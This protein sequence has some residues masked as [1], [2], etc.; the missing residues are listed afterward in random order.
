MNKLGQKLPPLK[1]RR[2][3]KKYQKEEDEIKR[4]LHKANQYWNDWKLQI[5]SNK[6]EWVNPR[7]HDERKKSILCV[8][9]KRILKT[10]LK[11]YIGLI[12]FN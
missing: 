9:F 10:T 4:K 11:L 5:H 2:L 6:L 3:S 12:T 8:F 1:K 7:S